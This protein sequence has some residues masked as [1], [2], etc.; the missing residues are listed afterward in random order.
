[1]KKSVLEHAKNLKKL[2]GWEAS[3]ITPD[4]SKQQREQAYHLRVEKRRRT[5]AG[6]ENLII[7]N[8]EIVVKNS[9]F[10]KE[11]G[12]DRNDH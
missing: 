12:R 10:Q 4:M 5:E 9:H 7:K 3:N 1:M 6:E 8:G 11:D 2:E